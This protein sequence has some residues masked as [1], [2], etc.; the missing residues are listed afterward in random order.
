MTPATIKVTLG[1]TAMRTIML[2]REVSAIPLIMMTL[3]WVMSM[4]II[5]LQEA[6]T[7]PLDIDTN[8]GF[9]VYLDPGKRSLREAPQ[10]LRGKSCRLLWRL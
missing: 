6:N 9:I 5:A 8:L 7:N 2:E 4:T 3:I 1:E 10:S